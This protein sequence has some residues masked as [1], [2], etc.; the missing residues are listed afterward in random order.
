MMPSKATHPAPIPGVGLH[1]PHRVSVHVL[2][3]PQPGEVSVV[4]AVAAVAVA[5]AESAMA[6]AVVEVEEHLWRSLPMTISSSLRAP[7]EGTSRPAEV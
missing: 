4:V 2:H 5:V 6:V 7:E 1:P 3:Q